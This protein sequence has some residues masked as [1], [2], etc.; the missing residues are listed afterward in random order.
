M[1]QGGPPGAELSPWRSWHQGTRGTRR[2][3][4]HREGD[5]WHNRS[6]VH[7]RVVLG[8]L[9]G[10]WGPF[11]WLIEARCPPLGAGGAG[12]QVTSPHQTHL[13]AC[14]HPKDL[15]EHPLCLL[16]SS[17]AP[18]SAPGLERPILTPIISSCT[19]LGAHHHLLVLLD[20]SW[21]PSSPPASLGPVL[22]LPNSLWCPSSL[23]DPAGPILVPIISSCSCWTHL[24]ICHFLLVLLEPSWHPPRPGSPEAIS[25]PIISAWSCPNHLGTHY[26][27]LDPS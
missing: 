22:V 20:P 6:W 24:S 21:H 7:P 14:W 18:S 16:D 25:V 3:P 2:V 15:S 4:A 8:G 5:H 11:G 10:C 26:L 9:F 12:G 27:L 23:L 19:H 17:Q 1:G 13:T